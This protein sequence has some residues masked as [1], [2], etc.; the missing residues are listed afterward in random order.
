MRGCGLPVVCSGR[1]LALVLPHP[2]AD[3][4]VRYAV[5]APDLRPAGV[6]DLAQELVVGRALDAAQRGVGDAARRPGGSHAAGARAVALARV[7]RPERRSTQQARPLHRLEPVLA[8]AMCVERGGAVGTDD[9]QVLQ[10]V[11]VAHAVGVIEDEPHRLAMPQLALTAQLADGTLDTGFIQPGLEVA[12][13]VRG[14][15]DEDLSQRL[16]LRGACVTSVSGV[17]MLSPDVPAQE[18]F[19]EE[20]SIASCGAE[21][22]Q[23]QGL[24]VGERLRY[25][26]ARLGFRVFRHEQMFACRSDGSASWG[27]WIRTNTSRL[28]RPAGCHYTTPQ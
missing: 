12:A 5:A 10:S 22:Q 16:A 19:L 17:E 2:L 20:R 7:F 9:P 18:P 6:G 15:T 28:Q 23:A 13:R 21:P 24:R 1:A 26:V 4:V 8:T 14:A 3:R 11:V 25:R 27:G